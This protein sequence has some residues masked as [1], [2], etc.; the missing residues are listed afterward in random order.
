MWSWESKRVGCEWR[1]N[2]FSEI[3]LSLHH[4]RSLS[5]SHHTRHH[6]SLI[7]HV[8]RHD[9]MYRCT[10]VRMHTCKF[11]HVCKHVCMNAWMHV[12]MF[13]W[14]HICICRTYAWMN[15]CI[16]AHI[17]DAWMHACMFLRAHTHACMHGCMHACLYAHMHVYMDV[18]AN[19]LMYACPRMYAFPRMHVHM[20][21]C[22]HARIHACADVQYSP[23]AGATSLRAAGNFYTW[24]K[25]VDFY[26][27]L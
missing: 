18:R 3:I 26:Q 13:A 11:M 21:A 8:C 25:I 24:A 12:C 5:L 7:M 1:K 10:H 9:C 16:N 2:G 4:A 14:M 20:H 6:I 23:G 15:V 19:I 17:H 22:I 27:N